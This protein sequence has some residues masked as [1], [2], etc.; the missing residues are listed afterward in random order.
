MNA[1]ESKPVVKATEPKPETTAPAPDP[2]AL[3]L[4]RDKNADES[5]PAT[6]AE[7]KSGQYIQL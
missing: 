3:A 2:K 6:P 5:K 7:I 1:D 4:T